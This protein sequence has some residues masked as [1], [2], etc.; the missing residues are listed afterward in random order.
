MP[1][2]TEQDRAAKIVAARLPVGTSEAF[3]WGLLDEHFGETPERFVGLVKERAGRASGGSHSRSPFEGK[4]RRRT[5]DEVLK[6]LAEYRAGELERMKLNFF[7]FDPSYH[8]ARYNFIR[9]VPKSRTPSYLAAHRWA[10]TDLL[11]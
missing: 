8:I 10:L 7:G 6:P 9:H 2:R 11:Q 3:R 4:Q 1:R 5:Q